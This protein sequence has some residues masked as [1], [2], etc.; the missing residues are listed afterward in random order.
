MAFRDDLHALEQRHEVLSAEAAAA[1]RERDHVRGMLDEARTRATR[2]VL[3]NLR[4]ASPCRADWAKMA[5]DERMRHCGDCKKDVFNVSEMTRDE[6]QALLVER[7]GSL[8]VRYFQRHDGTI[9]LADCTVGQKRARR[10][11]LVVIAGAAA[12]LAGGAAVALT[13]R[14]DPAPPQPVMGTVPMHYVEVELGQVPQESQ[15]G[16]AVHEA[17][18]K[19]VMGNK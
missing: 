19:F 12:M 1:A 4:V 7:T 13:S 16:T 14:S 8:C 3:E 18:G 11:K 15:L 6:A 17:N 10:R 9:L 2:P 5:G